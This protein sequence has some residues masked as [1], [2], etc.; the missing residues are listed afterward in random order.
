[1][2]CV[3]TRKLRH[4]IIDALRTLPVLG[5]WV[6]WLCKKQYHYNDHP[7]TRLKRLI[8]QRENLFIVEVGSNDGKSGDPLYP[9]IR[10]HRSWEVLFIEPVPFLFEQLK[11]NHGGNPRF[12]YEQV[13]IAESPQTLPFYYVSPDARREVPHLPDFCTQI[14]SFFRKNVEKHMA[15]ELDK[16]IIEMPVEAVPLATVLER[17][18]VPRIDVLLIDTEGYDWQVLR[19][20]DL[21]RYSPY[22]I[23]FEHKFLSPEDKAASREFLSGYEITDLGFDYLCKRKGG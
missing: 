21:S 13:A 20:L 14:G 9:L 17:Q 18:Q 2:D 19:Q 1:M 12:R 23:F 16:Y 6:G 4:R 7:T 10:S 22:I 8:G 5:R 11:R 3:A 15:D